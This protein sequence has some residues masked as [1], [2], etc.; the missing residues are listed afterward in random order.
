MPPSV[1]GLFTTSIP[2]RSRVNPG[3]SAR[4]FPRKSQHGGP[5]QYLRPPGTISSGLAALL[6]RCVPEV[7]DFSNDPL[8]KGAFCIKIRNLF[9]ISSKS[10]HEGVVSRNF[11][12]MVCRA[13]H[14]RSQ[15]AMEAS[16]RAASRCFMFMYFLLPHWVPAT[17]RSRAQ[18]SMRAELPSGKLPTTRV[19]RRIYRF[20]RSMTLL[21]RMR[22]QCSLGKSQ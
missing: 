17:W 22:V 19:R 16:S 18:T 3:A 21:V 10:G 20:S 2:S 1:S 4:A 15:P 9:K 11:R 6:G 13:W 7:L 14:E 8:K 5:V 12:K